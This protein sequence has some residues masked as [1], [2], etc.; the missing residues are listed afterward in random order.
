MLRTPLDNGDG[1]AGRS[2]DRLIDAVTT[3]RLPKLAGELVQRIDRSRFHQCLVAE[4][5]VQPLNDFADIV[6]RRLLLAVG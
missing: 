4:G 3:R 6:D 5:K 1:L 2:I